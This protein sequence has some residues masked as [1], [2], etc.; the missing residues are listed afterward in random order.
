MMAVAKRTISIVL[1]YIHIKIMCLC[2]R[3]SRPNS[4][5]NVKYPMLRCVRCYDVFSN[6]WCEYGRLRESVFLFKLCSR[7]FG[8][9][10]NTLCALDYYF[11]LLNLDLIDCLFYQ[12][13]FTNVEKCS[14]HFA[15]VLGPICSF[16]KN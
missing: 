4:S 9:I 8:G 11:D 16:L 7:F 15:F 12:V 6:R 3:I 14:N 10:S 2:V 1:V 5:E 13:R